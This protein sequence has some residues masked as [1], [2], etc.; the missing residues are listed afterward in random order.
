VSGR[1]ARKQN[2][3]MKPKNAAVKSVKTGKNH[4]QS[5]ALGR[6]DNEVYAIDS[7][8]HAFFSKTF[9]SNAAAKRFMA[10]TSTI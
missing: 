9:P 10:D 5:A 6:V 1:K 8:G 2:K 3:I 7:S 4:D